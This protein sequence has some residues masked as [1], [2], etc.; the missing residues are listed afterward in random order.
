MGIPGPT[1][2]SWY[3][4]KWVVEIL[5]VLPPLVIASVSAYTNFSDPA[6]HAAGLFLLGAVAWLAVA[7]TVK[8][9]HARSQDRERSRAKAYEGFRA[10]LHV[11]YCAARGAAGLDPEREDGQ[12]RATIHRVVDPKQPEELEQLV[13]YLGDGGGE[14]GRRFSVRSGIIGRAVREKAVLAAQR[15]NDD[16]EGFIRELVVEWSFTDSDARALRPDRKAWMAVPIFGTKQTVIAVVFLDSSVA[17]FFAPEVQQMITNG[18]V[19][20]TNFTEEA[21]R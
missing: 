15:T 11:L 12:L 18:C 13:S 20:L 6:K 8:V 19:G 14:P 17:D 16:I 1:R 9:L 4:K 2:D 7:S 5:S 10:A 21:Y 3:E